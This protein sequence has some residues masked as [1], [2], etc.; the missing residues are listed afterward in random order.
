VNGA[1]SF[2]TVLW[3]VILGLCFGSF[4]NA[5]VWR[6]HEQMEE[7]G[8]TKPKKA[9]LERLSISRGRSMCP[10][11]HHELAAKDLVPVLSWLY[12]KGKCR[13]CHK[14]IPD[15][16][17][18]EIVV[19][20]LF[21]GS[22]V[23]WPLHLG[24]SEIIVFALWLIM[25]VGLTVLF[26]YDLR[27]LILPDKVVYPL[28]VVALLMA[29]FSYKSGQSSL[30]HYALNTV[31]AILVGGG[32]FY[33]LFQISQ[34]RWIG[35]GDVKLGWVLGLF[36]GTP[37]RALLLIFVAAVAGSLVSIPLLVSKRL[38]RTSVIPFGPFLIMGA[39]VVQLFGSAIL[40]WYEHLLLN[41]N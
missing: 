29:G 16:P 37:S 17:I 31:L 5:A 21:V 23:F 11:C 24:G 10:H 26:I 7:Q 36:L 41:G 15:T 39:V 20:I 3:L 6:L 40:T 18:P 28:A 9:Y 33:V 19:P 34:G 2:V 1:Q 22:Y 27:W 4:S 38:K 13:Y 30:A 32:I 35:G 25:L 8:K 14:P 12:L